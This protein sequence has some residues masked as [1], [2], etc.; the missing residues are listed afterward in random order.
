MKPAH[1]K[2]DEI[3]L[4]QEN[5]R[6]GNTRDQIDALVKLV[7]EQGDKIAN[8]AESIV[9]YGL[10]PIEKLIVIKSNKKETPYISLEGNRRTVALKLLA[11]PHLLEP[12]DVDARLKKRFKT[13]SARFSRER[14]EPIEAV[15]FPDRESAKPWLLLR[16]DGDNEGR[17]TVRWSP[18]TSGRFRGRY[19][20]LEVI[21]LVKTHGNIAPEVSA[22][23]ARGFQ[24]STLERFLESVEPRNRLGLDL[25]EGELKTTLPLSEI[26]K[27]LSRLVTDIATNVVRSRNVNTVE[28]QL[29]YLDTFGVGERPNSKKKG[30]ATAV[31]A[32]LAAAPRSKKPAIVRPRAAFK[33]PRLHVIPRGVKLNVSDPKIAA[34]YDELKG[35]RL[36]SAPNAIAVLMRVFFEL[37]VDHFMDK[38]SLST[39]FTD[40][41]AGI[42]HKSL[43]KK[44]DE[45][46]EHIVQ[47]KS[48][49]KKEFNGIR[50]E[51]K[52]PSGPLSIN[53]FHDYV[54]NRFVTPK[55]RDLCVAWDNSRRLYE[56]IW[57]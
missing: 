45:V 11:A 46:I 50:K 49:M 32:L 12:L 1:L 28:Q 17:G 55:E 47:A 29:K 22:K 19:P 56:E 24:L 54:H 33:Q 21:D 52:D 42:R 26:I 3:G 36:D 44:A 41:K 43:S 14:V 10:S 57:K 51:L 25:V 2:I 18:F 4:D 53:L 39:Q 40:P 15:V 23:L 38:N 16:H 9:E 31:S 5:P 48:A 13:L 30:A 6:V 20:A 35:L 34:I 8:L 7:E 27:P 37:S